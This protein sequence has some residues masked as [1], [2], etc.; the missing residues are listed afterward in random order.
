MRV[1]G[2]GEIDAISTTVV[3]SMKFPALLR[4]YLEASVRLTCVGVPVHEH[5][6]HERGEPKLGPRRFTLLSMRQACQLP[7]PYQYRDVTTRIEMG[8]MAHFFDS[9]ADTKLERGWH[10]PPCRSFDVYRYTSMEERLHFGWRRAHE[11][12]VFRPRTLS[13]TENLN[14]QRHVKFGHDDAA[15]STPGA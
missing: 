9:A 7:Q 1:C 13:P 2:R 3:K 15:F 10:T 8:T 6:P 5:G 4:R 12:W 14:Q 11:E